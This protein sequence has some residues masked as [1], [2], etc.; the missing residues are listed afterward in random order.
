MDSIDWWSLIWQSLS[1]AIS[2]SAKVIADNPWTWLAL[3]G[4]ALVGILLPAR[5]RRRRW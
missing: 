3:I 1:S 4:L 5:R 2:M